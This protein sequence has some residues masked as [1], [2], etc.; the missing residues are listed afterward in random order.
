MR[1]YCKRSCNLCSSMSPDHTS[2]SFSD[3]C[4][5]LIVCSFFF[6]AKSVARVKKTNNVSALSGS[7][8]FYG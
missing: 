7:F 8:G 2:K 4:I 5:S 1:E 6:A 3:V